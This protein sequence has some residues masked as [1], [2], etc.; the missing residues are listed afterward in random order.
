M[1]SKIIVAGVTSLYMAVGVQEFPLSYE[2]KRTPL[3][4]RAGVTGAAGHIA[5]VL[6]TLGNDVKL[7]TVAGNDPA[8]SAIR[9]ELRGQRLLGHGVVDG[10]ATSLGVV[11]V[12]PDAAEWDSHTL[13]R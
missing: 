7:C 12:A 10:G 1:S 6:R 9:N 4:M 3:W 2:P 5:T 13:R 11:L 8:G